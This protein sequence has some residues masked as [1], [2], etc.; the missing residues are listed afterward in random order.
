[1]NLGNVTLIYEI[2]IVCDIDLLL[3]FM[4]SGHLCSNLFFI[5][6]TGSKN[7]NDVVCCGSWSVV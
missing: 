4:I 7:Y 6:F 3:L 1:M 2:C 5:L